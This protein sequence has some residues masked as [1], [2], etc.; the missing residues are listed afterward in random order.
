MG[1]AWQFRISEGTKH[2]SRS[3][4]DVR[5]PPA[6]MHRG[7]CDSGVVVHVGSLL[8]ACTKQTLVAD[9]NTLFKIVDTVNPFLRSLFNLGLE[10][11]GES[12]QHVGKGPIIGRCVAQ[13][14]SSFF[15]RA[16]AVIRW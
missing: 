6:I 10:R 7:V 16:P 9:Q 1:M 15:H 8:K 2:W 12:H 13:W 4:C 5:L 11:G 3:Y 14:I